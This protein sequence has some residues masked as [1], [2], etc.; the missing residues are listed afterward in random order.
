MNPPLR[1]PFLA[2]PGWRHV[3]RTWFLTLLVG[4]WFGLVFAGADRFTAQ[5]T[6]RVRVHLDAELG[7][8]LVPAFTVVYMSIYLVFLAAPFVLRAR[9]EITTLALAQSITIS[10]AGIGFLLIPAKLAYPPPTDAELGAWRPLFQVADRLNLDYNL[11]P[12]LHVALTVV[13]LE[14]Y[15][16]HAAGL[17]RV[18]LRC[19]GILVAAAT[20]FTHQHHLID[21]LTGYGLAL[22]VARLTTKP[23]HQNLSA[24][25]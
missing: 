14:L 3:G 1:R 7:I 13:C 18:L 6:T 10:A 9:R 5:R 16:A 22:A 4:A 2:W 8:P 25:H 17:V 15:A 19:W 21:V 11:V 23:G 24:L 20:L 12:S